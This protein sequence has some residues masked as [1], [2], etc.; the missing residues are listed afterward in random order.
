[1]VKW[2]KGTRDDSE[3][4]RGHAYAGEVI[5]SWCS[6]YNSDKDMVEEIRNGPL[7]REALYLSMFKAGYGVR[8]EQFGAL[9][10]KQGS[11]RARKFKNH[12]YNRGWFQEMSDRHKWGW[13][14]EV[15][16]QAFD[17]MERLYWS[18]GLPDAYYE[19]Q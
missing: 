4:K 10:A 9:D 18:G 16:D 19:D 1:M 14:H 15:L 6:G 11:I 17:R 3:W 8:W 12:E 7:S 5:A 2:G 13:R